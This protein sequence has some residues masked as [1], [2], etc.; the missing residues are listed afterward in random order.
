MHLNLTISMCNLLPHYILMLIVS[1][2]LYL[3]CVSYPPNPTSDVGRLRLA[4]EEG[5]LNLG[6]SLGISTKVF[7]LG[8][9]YGPGR[10][11]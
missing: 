9:I 11:L 6:Q 4:A 8:G 2:I 1:K 7:R 5:W 3:S 10:R